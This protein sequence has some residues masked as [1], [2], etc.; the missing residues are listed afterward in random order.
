MSNYKVPEQKKW[1][2]PLE[3]QFK[4]GIVSFFDHYA[5]DLSRIRKKNPY[6]HQRIREYLCFN[7][8]PN[9]RVLEIGTCDGSALATTRPSYGLGIDCSSKM[10]ELAQ[11]NYPQL[12]FQVAFA[13][14]LDLSKEEPF[15]YIILSDVIGYF[16]DIQRVFQKLQPLCHRDTRVIVNW[17]SRLWQPLISLAEKLGLKHTLPINNWTSREDMENIL[18]L[19]GF[20]VIKIASRELLPKKIPLLSSFCNKMLVNFWPFSLFAWTNWVVAKPPAISY[21]NLP[22]VSIVCPCRNEAGNIINILKR[23]PEIGSWTELIFVEGNSTDNTVETLKQEIAAYQGSLKISSLTQSGKGKGDAVRL[24]FAHAT[25]DIFMIL[26]ADLTVPPEILPD[27]YKAI[28]DGKGEFING[29]RLVYPM[30][31]QAMRFANILG[32]KA[33]SMMFTFLLGQKFKDTLCGTKVLS[34]RNYQNIVL[35]RAF[36]GDFDPFGDFDLLFGA[37]KLNLKIVDFPVRYR[38]RIYGTTN[39]QRWRAGVILLSMCLYAYRKFKIV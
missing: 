20:E 39:I 7:I 23:T 32:N 21:P 28:V 9:T 34:K 13:E 22:S 6:Y 37:A 14:D 19:A 38:E 27:F 4:Q 26:D 1:Q 25:G 33:F 36:F 29:S 24:G 15:D 31:D 10:I 17:Y 30:Q 8:L 11:K 12:H 35:G 3:A 2:D 5:E 18:R 16:Y